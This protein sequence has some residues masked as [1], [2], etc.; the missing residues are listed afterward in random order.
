MKLSNKVVQFGTGFLPII[1][2][3]YLGAKFANSYFMKSIELTNRGL[4]NDFVSVLVVCI[5]PVLLLI[6]AI[7]SKRY[8][9]NVMYYSSVAAVVLPLIGFLCSTV[10]SDDGHIVSF[11]LVVTL[12][13]IPMSLFIA[14][15]AGT[16]DGVNDYIF[17]TQHKCMDY[18]LM[19]LCFWLVFLISIL[20]FTFVK[21]KQQMIKG[22][23]S[24]N[25]ID[26]TN[27]QN[28]SDQ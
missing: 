12:A 9:L 13:I 19:Y 7:I 18:E 11:L 23:F 4:E 3:W 16:F 6:S 14:L 27:Q 20:I 26:I 5:I 8:N 10:I 17:V 15:G 22:D 25:F 2:L 1:F 24:K 28:Q 21:Q